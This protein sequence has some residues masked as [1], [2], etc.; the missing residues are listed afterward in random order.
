MGQPLPLTVALPLFT[1]KGGKV[2]KGNAPNGHEI[3]SFVHVEKTTHTCVYEQVMWLEA[4]SQL[5]TILGHRKA[6]HL[7]S[8]PG[9]E[10]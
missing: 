4:Q 9:G 10:C 2:T 7:K 1:V 6:K 8:S 5:A 3:R